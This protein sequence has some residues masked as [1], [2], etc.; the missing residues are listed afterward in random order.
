[1]KKVLFVGVVGAA[2]A[3]AAYK[4]SQSRREESLWAEA[5]ADTWLPVEEQSSEPETPES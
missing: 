4:Y 3:F 5:T 1:M 2:V